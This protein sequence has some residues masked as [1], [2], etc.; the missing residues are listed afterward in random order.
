MK[1]AD[2]IKKITDYIQSVATERGLT[3]RDIANLCSQKGANVAQTT[4]T[5]MFNKPSSMTISTLLKVCDGL[6]LNLNAIFHSL[7]NMKTV[8]KN[9]GSRFRY[10]INDDA[11]VRYPGKY[12]I[13]FLSTTPN[14][15]E[16]LI[17]GLQPFLKKFIYISV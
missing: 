11:F 9:K 17:H 5:K 3:H 14:S 1:N 10:D 15:E 4:I 7:E 12:H 16:K 8:G 6:D 13:F 2:I